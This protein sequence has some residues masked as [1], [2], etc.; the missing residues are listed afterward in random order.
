MPLP[1]SA[2]DA[3]SNALPVLVTGTAA[4]PLDLADL[5][6]E[7]EDVAHDALAAREE[8]LGLH[9]AVRDP[10]FV[11]LAQLHRDLRDAMFVEIPTELRGWIEDLREDRLPARPDLGRTLTRLAR[12]ADATP[13]AG[14]ALQAALS[15]V[16]IFESV[17]LRLLAVAWRTEDFERLGGDEDDIDAIAWEEVECWLAAPEV[18]AHPEV[19]PLH[20]MWA[21]AAVN[22]ARDTAERA[23]ALR[24]SNDD[25]REELGMRARLRAALRELRL[26]ESVLLENA[27]S[28]LLGHDRLELD[29]LKEHRPLALEGLSRQA[30]DQ[31]VSRGRRALTHPPQSWPRRRQAALFDLLRETPPEE[32][33]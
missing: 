4:G 21:S 7:L 25:T 15:E 20:I 5:R 28:A 10:R 12:P 30:M 27:L 32:E 6:G 2:A 14:E 29:I 1:V 13:P 17:R 23:T 31:R 33:Q 26:P 11:A 22:L 3:V 19:R 24:Q 18:F 9:E 16:L 8:G